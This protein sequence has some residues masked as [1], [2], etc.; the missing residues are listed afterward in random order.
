MKWPNSLQGRLALAL[1]GGLILL[2]LVAALI[3][4]MIFRDEMD[5]VFDS[6][7]EETAQRILPLAVLDILSRDEE[8]V[9]Q[10]IA[11]LRRHEEYFTYLVH[12]EQGRILLR[13]HDADEEDFPPFDGVGFQQ[14]ADHRVYFDAALQGKI[15]IAVAEPLGHR[16]EAAREAL[17][18]LAL[19]L[20]VVIPLSLIGI[21]LIVGLSLRPVR[22]FSHA[23]ASRGA[24]DLSTV[25]NTNLPHE[26][27]PMA[28]AVN[29]L[30]DRLR[31]T[32]E[33]ER[34][35]TANAAHELRTPV[36]A[37]LAQTQ[38]LMAE[39]S[40]PT[41]ASRAGEIEVSLKRLTRLSEK[42]MQLARAEG[43][44]MRS[45]IASD[46]RTVLRLV[47]SDF[48]RLTEG[49]PVQATL[50][51]KPVLS[52]IDPDAFAILARNL[53]ENALRHGRADTP[54]QVFLT[55]SGIFRVINVGPAVP[56]EVLKRLSAQFERGHAIVEGSGLGLSIVQAIA[57]GAQATLTL[58]SP[59]IGKPDGFEAVF[60]L[61]KT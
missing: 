26:I 17:I 43:G 14:T 61:P 22:R 48:E 18:G 33:A 47:L 3:T 27:I 11:A 55:E 53:I 57:E 46:M 21:I 12:D 51:P 1:G 25:N 50:S 7:L 32:L 20:I 23:L 60:E 42:L 59:A 35:F 44:R 2:W 10:R 19:P 38:R 13:S 30:L 56:P 9:S 16:A 41:A 40:E 24:H 31:R 8:G 36:A 39:T 28:E 54:V 5:E 45:E 4:A 37:A 52:G 6:A 15:T 49:Q 34:S 58:H 29:E